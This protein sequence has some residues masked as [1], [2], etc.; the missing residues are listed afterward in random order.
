MTTNKECFYIGVILVLA[1]MLNVVIIKGALDKNSAEEKAE[2]EIVL[3]R[4]TDPCRGGAAAS[5]IRRTFQRGE[6]L[7]A[8]TGALAG[9]EPALVLLRKTF[10]LASASQGGR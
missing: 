6:G 2:L 9:E 10:N 7:C 5:G 1:V 8:R 4:D 3:G